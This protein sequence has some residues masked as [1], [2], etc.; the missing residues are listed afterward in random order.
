MNPLTDIIQRCHQRHKEPLRQR[1]T[2]TASVLY[3]GFPYCFTVYCAHRYPMLLD[4]LEQ[5]DISFMPIGRAPKNDQGPS[6][7]GGARFSERQRADS[8]KPQYWRA[9][10]GIQVYTGI[11]SQR[12]GARWHDIEFKYEALCTA[13][14]AVLACIEALVNAVENPLL[15][16]SKE[17]G[18]VFP[19]ESQTISIQPL[20]HPNSIST[21]TTLQ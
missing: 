1:K 21:S 4:S 2:V 7:F 5:A 13:P 10:C 9:S 17:G 3:R 12:D 18:C 20:R 6:D 16:L 15:T 14:D 8:W 19:A 11:P